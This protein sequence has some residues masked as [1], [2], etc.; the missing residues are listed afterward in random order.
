MTMATLSNCSGTPLP[1]VSNENIALSIKKCSKCDKGKTVDHYH[2]KGN[3]INSRCKTCVSEHMK[4]LRKQQADMIKES[5]KQQRIKRVERLLQAKR[6]WYYKNKAQMMQNNGGVMPKESAQKAARRNFLR[7]E[8]YRC[9]PQ[10]RIAQT[11]RTITSRLFKHKERS[12]FEYIGASQEFFIE[13]I[14][15][16]LASTVDGLTM[17]NYGGTW[18]LDHVVPC[19]SFD[20]QVEEQRR[21]CFNWV[22]VRPLIA[23]VN[24]SKRE[25]ID[26]QA[27]LDQ[28]QTYHR[29]KQ[30]ID[31]KEQVVDRVDDLIKHVNLLVTA[32]TTS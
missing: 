21:I 2:K 11:L 28:V 15:F 31:T 4:E 24:M 26:E 29:F 8:R 23:A 18:H 1:L 14:Q 17:E 10:F 27:L 30:T 32:T 12:T 20:L 16:Q 25:K 13:W 9:N 22:N 7:K 19:N 5:D 3:G 6:Q